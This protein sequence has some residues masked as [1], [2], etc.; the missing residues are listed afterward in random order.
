MLERYPKEVKLVIKHFPLRMHRYAKKAAIAALA[1][2]RQG[3]YWEYHHKI[4]ENYR[5]L[6]DEKIQEMAGE[7]ELDMEKF[8]KDMDSPEIEKVIQGDMQEGARI[9]VRG[10][11]T[12]YINGRRLR[13]RSLQGFMQMIE[14][15]LKKR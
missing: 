8:K 7:L 11:P 4:Y 15:E 10:T 12:I 5:S 9:G 2:G 14:S 3:K 13:N 6:N 1:A